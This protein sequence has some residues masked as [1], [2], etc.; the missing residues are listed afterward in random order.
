VKEE[1][2]KIKPTDRLFKVFNA[3]G[4]KNGEVI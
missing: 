3:D 1:K 4:T 2:I